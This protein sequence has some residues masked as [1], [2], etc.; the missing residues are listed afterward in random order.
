MLTPVIQNQDFSEAGENPGDAEDWSLTYKASGPGWA[1]FGENGSLQPQENFD[2]FDW[3]AQ[4]VGATNSP[5]VLSNKEIAV[6]SIDDGNNV[7]EVDN[8]DLRYLI[9]PDS[10]I[11]V[12]TVTGN[13]TVGGFWKVKKVNNKGTMAM[14]WVEGDV[15]LTPPT[16]VK[17]II[18]PTFYCDVDG[19]G[20]P[21]RLVDMTSYPVAPIGAGAKAY[22]TVNRGSVQEVTFAGGETTAQDVADVYNA[23]LSGVTATV[24]SNELVL[25]TESK[26]WN[27]HLYVDAGTSGL[28]YPDLEE[29]GRGQYVQLW[30]EFFENMAA[31]TAE[32]I[33]IVMFSY[34]QHARV[35]PRASSDGGWIKVIS[36]HQGTQAKL[37]IAG[38]RGVLQSKASWPI[39]PRAGLN[40]ILF[41]ELNGTDSVSITLTTGIT[42]A[43]EAV[44][45]IKAKL[46][47]YD[48]TADAVVE[49]EQIYVGAYGSIECTGGGANLDIGF[50]EDIVSYGDPVA[51]NIGFSDGEVFGEDGE[52]CNDFDDLVYIVALFGGEGVAEQFDWGQHF[53]SLE[54]AGSLPGEIEN[55]LLEASTANIAQVN[56]ANNEISIPTSKI[57]AYR[58]RSKLEISDSTGNDGEYTVDSVVSMGLLS[59]IILAE[60]LPDSTADGVASPKTWLQDNDT[61]EDGWGGNFEDGWKNPRL[62]M[63]KVFGEPIS[64][65][66]QID[67]NRNILWLAVEETTMVSLQ[68]EGKEYQG[69]GELVTE[70]NDKL[71][72]VGLFG[73]FSFSYLDGPDDSYRLTFGY[74]PNGGDF[75]SHESF[76]AVESTRQRGKDIRPYIGL[77]NLSPESKERFVIY[78][79]SMFD[80]INGA[81]PK[82]GEL[83]D[84]DAFLVDPYSWVA[85]Q[86]D[87]DPKTEI[88]YALENGDRISSFNESE[89]SLETSYVEN[90]I[91]DGWGG[92]NIYV[93]LDP[94]L[95]EGPPTFSDFGLFNEDPG[96]STNYESFETGWS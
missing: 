75:N 78:P 81:G 40:A 36:E 87:E 47:E 7:F 41:F 48:P 45:D 4:L 74:N 56:Q 57:K 73:A 19:Y 14:I 66:L 51:L 69:I 63:G 80:T 72:G 5:Y 29:Q 39:A 46:T 22:F 71:D 82:S 11:L 18:P 27:S 28:T 13:D 55:W 31:A 91:I 26:G 15:I 61:F 54:E 85:W 84:E 62:S 59:N 76:F 38:P 34:W 16:T 67:A 12:E 2:W 83:T 24:E 1:N 77:A 58:F 68:I 10:I 32:E 60:Q 95:P 88:K 30:E 21:A 96:P 92:A 25:E 35:S 86:I 64:F 89:P 3:F 50:E 44:I 33:G 42:T 90:F 37:K 65:P 94:D 43:E 79:R 17:L 52:L 9:P 93:S 20:W 53:E 23:Q 8:A 6:T 49:G 70:L